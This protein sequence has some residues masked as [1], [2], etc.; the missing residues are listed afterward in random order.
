MNKVSNSRFDVNFLAYNPAMYTDTVAPP[1]THHED[2]PPTRT[3]IIHL[4]CFETTVYRPPYTLAIQNIYLPRNYSNIQSSMRPFPYL[5][6]SAPLPNLHHLPKPTPHKQHRRIRR[7]Q[8]ILQL[9]QHIPLL[10]LQLL[11]TLLRIRNPCRRIP[12]QQVLA[13]RH[14]RRPNRIMHRRP[15]RAQRNKPQQRRPACV[16]EHVQ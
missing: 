14:I 1:Q 5:A 4:D 12:I 9:M 10:P 2:L 13:V 3:E 16:R 11:R 7:Q 15:A 8:K 6:R